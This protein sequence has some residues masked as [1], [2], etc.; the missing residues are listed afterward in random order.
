MPFDIATDEH[1]EKVTDLI[2][3]IE[4][5]KQ[6]GQFGSHEIDAENLLLIDF[7]R[8][9]ENSTLSETRLFLISTDQRLRNWDYSR[10]EYQPT[11]LLPSHWMSLLL[12]Y[13]SRTDSDYN[14]FTSFLKLKNGNASLKLEHP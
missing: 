5:E 6:N 7:L 11:V 12:R 3:E 4:K 9:G 14:A 2:S 13:V 1:K 10:S 8:D